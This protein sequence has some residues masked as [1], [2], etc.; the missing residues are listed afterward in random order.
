MDQANKPRAACYIM[1]AHEQ[2]ALTARREASGVDPAQ[3]SIGLALSGGGVR[4]ATFCIGLLRA[5]AKNGVLHRFDYLSTVSGGGYA[6]AAF[7]RLFSKK[8]KAP[9]V[10]KGVAD[11]SSLLLW[12]LRSNGR[13]LVPAG[14]RDLLQAWAGQLRGFV[15]TQFEITTMIA[16]LSCVIVLP[17][18]LG[19]HWEANSAPL[20]S[21]TLWW[22][23]MP[24]AG[25]M[26]IFMAFAYWWSR[27]REDFSVGGDIVICTC[28]S[29]MAGYLLSPLCSSAVAGHGK[30]TMAVIGGILLAVPLSR[31]WLLLRQLVQSPHPA[32]DRVRF[33]IG[34]S[35][36]LK[37]LLLLW[38]L[39]AADLLSWFMADQVAV[40]FRHGSVLTSAGLAAMLIGVARFALPL[41]QPR[42]NKSSL[43]QL[44]LALLANLCGLIL[45]ALVSLFWLS[46]LQYF[47]F[48][49]PLSALNTWMHWLALL[50]PGLARAP[51]ADIWL[52]W[53]T[54]AL[55]SLVYI[56]ITGNNL[57]LINRSSLHAFYRSRIAR[58]YV[59]VGNSP[60][61]DVTTAPQRFPASPLQPKAPGAAN[62]VKKLTELLDGDDIGLPDY[63]PH[64]HGGPIHL[65]NCCINQTIDDRTDTYNADRK[66]VYLTVS[67]LGLETGTKSPP[68]HT[69]TDDP[70]AH[71]TLAEWIAVSG[72][73]AGSGMGSLTRTG[74]SAL[75]FLSGF[76][77][78]YWWR[79]R[80]NLPQFWWTRLG[81]SR[82]ALQEML[83]RF[84]GLKSPVWYLSDG[85]HF[86]NTGVYSLLKRELKLIVLADCGAD[87]SYVFAD[88]ENLAR[89]A[90]M[91]MD[92]AI[93]FIDPESLPPEIG[94]SL[95]ARFGT[96]DSIMPGPGNQH[97]LLARITYPG[98]GGTGCLLVVKP[99]L[100]CDLPLD[101][102]GY[103]DRNRDFPQQS[104]AQQFFDESQWES[105]CQLG[106]VLGAAIDASLLDVLPMLTEA[107]VA[108]RANTVSSEDQP[109]TMT[110]RQRVGATIGASLSLG[111]LAT[112]ALT[113]W[114]AWDAHQAQA[115]S[116]GQTVALQQ[117]SAD[118]VQT[119][120]EAGAAYDPAM[121]KRISALLQ[122]YNDAHD[123]E[124]MTR[125]MTQLS[126]TLNSTCG[127]LDS[128]HP[129][130]ERCLLD[131]SAL[132]AAL[133]KLS[134]WEQALQ[135]Y[136]N[137]M[138]QQTP[139]VLLPPTTDIA[140][141]AP[142]SVV[143]EAVPIDTGATASDEPMPTAAATHATTS[144]ASAAESINS[145]SPT[146][147]PPVD[148]TAL[149]PST[150]SLH[151]SNA[152]PPPPPPPPRPPLPAPVATPGAATGTA[153]E[154]TTGAVVA[155]ASAVPLSDAAVQACS[156][157]TVDQPQ[158]LAIYA[159]IYAESQRAMATTLLHQFG[160]FGLATPGIENVTATA[161]HSGRGA[162]AAWNKPVFLF[163]TYS[164]QAPACAHSLARWLA[165]QPGFQ[166]TTPTA[167]PLPIRLR[168]NPDVIELWLPA[169]STE[170]P[171]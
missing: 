115:R 50:V 111:A 121:H 101:V 155:A 146:A 40:V 78:G 11:D 117:G 132:R 158:H 103:A 143:P 44:P 43:A 14:A 147:A 95:C 140:T 38:V 54:V 170:P 163:S 157:A 65:I 138:S 58:T 13:Y 83:A 108:T 39:G 47:V 97:L 42:S 122:R 81:K 85:G 25:W 164:E 51:A 109:T 28:T 126:D 159:Q 150:A 16:L 22:L 46:A 32:Q 66:G 167:L 135:D 49:A 153:V 141:A 67:S 149:T 162:P 168:G 55:P 82:A 29:A 30:L 64:E 37:Y 12:W 133:T 6:G 96:P 139:V 31:V 79:N 124:G 119:D 87:P 171:R 161:S 61:A 45:I 94:A 86:D 35:T 107:G 130:R 92:T 144:T 48:V 21:G 84:P 160:A 104:T 112:V 33:T 110:R 148:E 77:L 62:D 53:L 57:Q 60:D 152:T 34:L 114:Q 41:L 27:D 56:A 7:G 10:E 113:S 74:I 102:A 125:I 89:K 151:P 129:L 17:H 105:Y 15:A 72:A 52:R 3:P 120:L 75:F 71:S 1:P 93:D 142:G 26:A 9:A 80:L 19:Y 20:L 73:A 127:R 59:S 116:N 137:V 165:T 70:L 2:A 88:L 4:S 118:A 166:T 8:A 136:R 145:L 128:T 131:Y 100:Y 99:R 123:S 98:S 154:S 156:G 24:L 134:S 5:L 69:G 23:A 36:A 90:R 68:L 169:A 63:R 91:D 18:L 106:E 76:R